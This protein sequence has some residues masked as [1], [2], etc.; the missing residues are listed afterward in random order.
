MAIH[1]NKAYGLTDESSYDSGLFIY[2]VLEYALVNNGVE[3]GFSD[4]GWFEEGDYCYFPSVY[5]EFEAGALKTDSILFKKSTN[6]KIDILKKY[7]LE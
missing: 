7:E 4:P 5:K 6:D 1:N 3:C 2:Q